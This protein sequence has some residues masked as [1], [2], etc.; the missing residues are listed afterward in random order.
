MVHA[1]LAACGG[2][3]VTLNWYPAVVV[4]ASAATAAGIDDFESTAG[5]GATN[6][7]RSATTSR[8]KNFDFTKIP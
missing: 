2:L 5:S 4:F 6:A 7:P 3:K 1:P 8:R